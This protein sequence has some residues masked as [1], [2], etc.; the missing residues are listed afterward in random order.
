M[1][2]HLLVATDGSKLSGKAV[3][4]AIALA[5]PLKAKLT[6]FY[7]APEAP[8]PVYAD[9]VV[10]QPRVAA[11]VPAA[12][13]KE[14][15]RILDPI[16]GTRQGRGRRLQHRACDRGRAVG[17]DPRRRE[18]GALRRDRHGLAWPPRRRR[19]PARLRD[20]EGAGAQQAAGDRGPLTRRVPGIRAAVV[21]GSKLR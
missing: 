3:A 15:A 19:H 2:K 5:K 16:V 14:A 4:H 9:G 7:A 10:F 8:L 13:D 20:A 11:G 1:F 6:A 12:M 17:G 21:P 18:E